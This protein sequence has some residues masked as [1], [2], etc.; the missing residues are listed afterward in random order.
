MINLQ[1]AMNPQNLNI[2]DAMDEDSLEK[3]G[4][5]LKKGFEIDVQSRQ[6][7]M[8]ENESWMKLA[9]QYK[10]NKTFPWPGAANV[11]Y[12]LVTTAAMQFSAR[13]YPSLVP[14]QVPV[15][16]VVR[17]K[18][19]DED[20]SA[21]ASAIAKHMNYQ[22]MYEMD[23]WEEDMDKL[24]LI[25]PISGCVFK[26]TY[27]DPVKEKNVSEL[28]LAKDVV[29]NY[30]AKNI[31]E[32]P[33]VS[34]IL[35]IH[36]DGIQTRVRKGIFRDVDYGE[37]KIVPTHNDGTT[38]QEAPSQKD[39]TTPY[40]F[41]ECHCRY[42]L[43]EDGYPEP[44]VVTFEQNTGKVARIIPR[45]YHELVETNENEEVIEIQPINYFTKFGFI[46]NPDGGF[47][48]MGFGLLL[49]PL[50][51]T[52]NTSLNQ[53]LDAG[54]L[55]TLQAGFLG[56]GVRIRGGEYKMSPNEWKVVNANVDDLRK[57]IFPLPVKEPSRVLFELLGLLIQSGKE[58]A[59]IS[60]IFVGKMP[61]QNTP[62]T[63]TMETVKQGMA[64]FTAIYKRV[65]RSL[66]KE[67][68]K[69]F[70]LNKLFMDDTIDYPVDLTRDAYSTAYLTVIPTADP[71]AA[72]D[73]EKQMKAEFALQL[74]AQGLVNPQVATD[75]ILTAMK[76]EN[77]EALMQIPEKGPSPE[78]QK[79]QMEAQL[80]QQDAQMKAQLAQQ[81][82]QM[83]AAKIQADQQVKA[84]EL[85]WKEQAHQQ[86]MRQKEQM[87]RLEL[88][89]E[90][91][92]A[93]LEAATKVAGAEIE[94]RGKVAK[95]QV[96]HA[97]QADKMAAARELN[98]AKVAQAKKGSNDSQG[99][100]EG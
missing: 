12:P 98:A 79:F 38:R 28:V 61:G 24:C 35:E 20:K 95:Q 53:L 88:M 31:D 77:K 85:K 39:S 55:S 32:A 5:E 71:D 14:N 10:E 17:G 84:M 68:K 96:D 80:K 51:D 7:W 19:G 23:D 75:M 44:Y 18:E 33:R 56:K 43:D 11:K 89:I 52:I 15:K 29:V 16:A 9:T 40:T 74:A 100:D 93:Q 2:A 13:A 21:L 4:E 73:A 1:E 99:S 47:Y 92:K 90:Q 64:V 65:Y 97:I 58:L 87:H 27:Y 63:T 94:V 26:K 48:D 76:F 57:H 82:A 42:D 30:W 86:E 72:S 59:S 91:Q 83:D 46:P 69:L 67:Y 6:K 34:H 54:T 36:E 37:P 62:A 49:G 66:D 45:F 50:N 41:I 3:I 70:M 78:E 22:L 60:E 81:K 25:L 8:D